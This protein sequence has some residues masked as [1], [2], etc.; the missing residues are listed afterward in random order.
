[1]RDSVSGDS[2]PRCGF[3]IS[4]P[5]GSR[6]FLLECKKPIDC[7]SGCIPVVLTEQAPHAFMPSHNAFNGI[8]VGRDR[9]D[10]AIVEPLMVAFLMTV[11]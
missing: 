1:V 9:F 3:R 4:P 2:D 6:A 7:K 8:R 11:D 10:E 5:G